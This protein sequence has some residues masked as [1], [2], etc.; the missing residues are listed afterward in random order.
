VTVTLVEANALNTG[1]GRAVASSRKR[2]G[3]SQ[4][5]LADRLG[6]LLGRSMDATVITRMEQ[7]RRSVAIHELP[8]LA[9]ALGVAMYDLL[10]VDVELDVAVRSARLRVAQ[11][12]HMVEQAEAAHRAAVLELTEARRALEGLT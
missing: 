7:G 12:Q 8:A 5:D 11:A 2:L 9:A 6:A 4:A 3:W 10:P 1:L